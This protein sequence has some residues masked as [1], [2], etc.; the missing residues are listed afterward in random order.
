[1]ETAIACF[2]VN[3]PLHFGMSDFEKC[4]GEKIR[5]VR[6]SKMP[7]MTIENLAEQ[8]GLSRQT[9][10]KIEKGRSP[11]V[12]LLT[13]AKI[14]AALKISVDALVGASSDFSQMAAEQ[15]AKYKSPENGGKK[16]R[17]GD[18]DLQERITRLRPMDRRKM[19]KSA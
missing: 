1:M 5:A 2:S 13:I 4:L 18:D 14:A 11:N 12:A 19:K 9:I 17:A 10:T 8:A 16:S 6:R 7:E 3:Y 15:P